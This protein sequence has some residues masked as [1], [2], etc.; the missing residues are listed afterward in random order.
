VD[1]GGGIE[2][3]VLRLGRVACGQHGFYNA[4]HPF[5]ALIGEGFDSERVIC[6]NLDYCFTN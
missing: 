1:K 2:F 4:H 6:A 5:I 3:I